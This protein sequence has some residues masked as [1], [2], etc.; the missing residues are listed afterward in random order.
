MGLE[1]IILIIKNGIGALLSWIPKIIDIFKNKNLPKTALV[2]VDSDTGYQNYWHIGSQN[3]K[4][5]LQFVCNFMATNIVDQPVAVANSTLEGIKGAQDLAVISIKD[6]NS[7]YWGSY[8]IPPKARTALSICFIVHPLKMPEKGMPI[9]LKVVVI[10][11]FG[12]K[13][14]VKNVIF[15]ST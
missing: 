9:R 11:Q 10:D 14:R 5:I 6:V 8:D 3:D 15:R 1:S 12:N 4:P 7:R 13:Y 2:I